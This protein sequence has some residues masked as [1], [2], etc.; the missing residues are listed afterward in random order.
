VEVKQ[1]HLIKISNIF[2]A[3]ENVVANLDIKRKWGRTKQCNR[4]R[5]A[6]TAWEDNNK[7]KLHKPRFC[8]EC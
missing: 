3:L 1:Q 5:Q 2:A 4:E 7:L 8:V 6:K